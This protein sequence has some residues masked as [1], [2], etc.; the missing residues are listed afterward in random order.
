[1]VS[2][3]SLAPDSFIN[4]S[5][6]LYLALPAVALQEMAAT[7]GLLDGRATDPLLVG[8]LLSALAGAAAVFLLGRLGARFGQG[9]L[10][11]V[12]LAVAPGMVNLCH[13]ATPE[14]WLILGA[15]ATL[16][17]ALRHQEGTVSV[18]ALGLVLGLTASTKYTAAALTVPC[19]LAVCLRER[20]PA[21]RRDLAA[22]ATIACAAAFGAAVLLLAP[23]RALAGALHLPDARLLHAESA[24]AFVRGLGRLLGVL[25]AVAFCLVVLA[26]RRRPVGLLLARRELALLGASAGAGFLLGTPY[27]ALRPLA[28]LSD[29]AFNEQTRHQYKGLQGASTSFLAYLALSRDLLT[30]PFL[31]AVGLG[32]LVAAGRALNRDRQAP[33]LAA[34]LLAPYLLVASGGHQAL[35]FLAAALPAAA[36]LAALGLSRVAGTRAHQ[37]AAILVVGRALLGALLVARLFLVDSRL[38]AHDWLAAHV[39]PGTTVDVITNHAGYAPRIP[40]GRTLR[41]VPT[42]S[43]EMAPAER[44]AE[45]AERYPAEGSAWLVLTESYYARF[46]QNPEQAPEHAH[47]FQEMLDGKRGFTVAARFRQD[48]AWRYPAEFLDPEI[49]ILRRA[50]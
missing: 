3:R 22:L 19:V 40:E 7:A 39:P 4:P 6:P 34:A 16:F 37:M 45:A 28:F 1:M 38:R 18:L 27:A 48:R 29:L 2:E 10:P 33:I 31:L 5:L 36:L 24:Y 47:F 43:R 42:L 15:C 9:L 35:R 32:L 30:A 41:V 23:G 25:A 26:W 46:L 14:A 8:R 13:F 44:F 11:A 20:G 12:L 17:L 21:E 50:P 49:V